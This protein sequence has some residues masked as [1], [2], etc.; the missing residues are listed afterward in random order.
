MSPNEQRTFTLSVEAV[1]A[2][3]KASAKGGTRH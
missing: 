2:K 1:P 3:A